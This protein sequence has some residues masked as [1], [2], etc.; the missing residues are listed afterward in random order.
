MTAEA[1]VEVAVRQI[2]AVAAA[3]AAVEIFLSFSTENHNLRERK[4]KKSVAKAT[5][6]AAPP[7]MMMALKKAFQRTTMKIA[8]AKEVLIMTWTM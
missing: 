2:L 3:V 4:L 6:M 7:M 1:A 8:Q 5:K